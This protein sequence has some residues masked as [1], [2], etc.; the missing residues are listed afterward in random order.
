MEN[1]KQLKKKFKEE[2]KLR[3]R[4][5]GCGCNVE[6][7]NIAMCNECVDD[8]CD[9]KSCDCHTYEVSGDCDCHWMFESLLLL[10]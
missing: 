5:V 1:K 8:Y 6:M 10:F 9:T 7:K 3:Y 4:R 2:W